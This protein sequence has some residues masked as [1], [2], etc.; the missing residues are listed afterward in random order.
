M[1]IYQNSIH[2]IGHGVSGY[3]TPAIAAHWSPRRRLFVVA[4]AF[5]LYFLAFVAIY[6]TLNTQT[7]LLGA[8]PVLITAWLFGLWGGML[9]L[10]FTFFISMLLTRLAGE[11]QNP[12]QLLIS[13]RVAIEMVFLF[14]FALIVGRLRD[15][16]LQ[17]QQQLASRQTMEAE[18]RQSQELLVT[19]QQLANVGSWE[20]D[21][22]NNRMQWSDQLYRI[23]GLQPQ[24]VAISYEDYLARVLPSDR[25]LVQEAIQRAHHN[26][27][28]FHFYERIVQ[29]DQS[30]RTLYSQGQVK[31]DA[32]TGKPIAMVGTCL[33]ITEFKQSE[34]QVLRREAI[35]NAVAF[36]AAQFLQSG[37]WMEKLDVVLASLGHAI[38]AN[39]ILLFENYPDE[40]GHL[41]SSQRYRWVKPG[42]MPKYDANRWQNFSL[43][44]SGF[45]H[46][47]KLMEQGESIYGPVSSLP[48]SEQ[49][50]LDL[51][52]IEGLVVMPIFVGEKWWGFIGVDYSHFETQWSM[53]AVEAFK[54]ATRLLGAAL[55]RQQSLE[56][57]R[58]QAARAHSLVDTA[59]RLNAQLDVQSIVRTVCDEAI[60]ALGVSVS[61]IS[62]YDGKLQS[63][64]YAWG[65]G[66]PTDFA[67]R[68]Q[69]L[70]TELDPPLTPDAQIEH[71]DGL[72]ITYDVQSLRTLPN[73]DLYTEMDLRTTI[74]VTLQREGRLI[75][76]LNIGTTGKPRK[77]SEDDLELLKGLADHAVTALENAR[78]YQESLRHTELL[79]AINKII[80]TVVLSPDLQGLLNTS[81]AHILQ[82]LNL[83]TGIIWA[84]GHYATQGIRPHIDPLIT[85]IIYPNQG[86]TSQDTLDQQKEEW[87][88]VDWQVAD[89][90][91]VQAEDPAYAFACAVG[92]MGLTAAFFIPL[93]NNGQQFGGI[94]VGQNSPRTWNV[95][96]IT[97][98]RVMGQQLNAAIERF[99]LYKRE[100]ERTWQVQQILELAPEGMLLLDAEQRVVLSNLAARKYLTL[101]SDTGIN[102]RLIH[103]GNESIAAFLQMPADPLTWHEVVVDSPQRHIFEIM[104]H[105][106]A[107]AST[108]GKAG[109]AADGQSYLFVLRDVTQE[110]QRH[111]YLQT[112]ERLATVGQL[113]AGI[114]H[115]FNNILTPILLYTDM[116]L[117]KLPA[118]SRVRHSLQQVLVA[119]NRAKELIF[120]ILAFGR[121]GAKQGRKLAASSANCQRNA[122]TVAR[123][124]TFHN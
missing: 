119:A 13:A 50:L 38:D 26:A 7:I 24:E 101:L 28:P 84:S 18:L 93:L 85:R 110:R 81:L 108:F 23:Y 8:L 97:L 112:Q 67:Q 117:A 60:K 62:L 43:T 77:F 68:V 106:L 33:D 105:S 22:V 31:V 115:D 91:A 1:N 111:E 94:I 53:M 44:A 98:M 66:V 57:S 100:H 73:A 114:A 92:H 121:Q 5:A 95:N 19:T 104:A 27:Q 88:K 40:Q 36:A 35:L 58:N 89:W 9:S 103:L 45:A 87:Q 51:Q 69:A 71:R 65:S 64:R 34:T 124:A 61:T 48:E 55:Y 79:E 78:L 21:I 120:Q 82:T 52:M 41:L 47:A 72:V 96:E 20:W 3:F 25:T 32:T 56:E 70:R 113:A 75:G 46:W 39:Q 102:E 10:P 17:M 2:R 54:T 109:R 74:N 123:G 14:G 12:W 83:T 63:F 99:D 6:P 15:L 90:Q 30:V 76:R 107:E 80:T 116:S 49:Q 29:P 11:E 42:Y 37:T 118:D 86:P 122:E 59:S 16:T 4:S